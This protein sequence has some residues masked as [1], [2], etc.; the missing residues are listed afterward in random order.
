MIIFERLVVAEK[1]LFFFF[2][3]EGPNELILQNRGN[4]AEADVYTKRR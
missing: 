1:F 4:G 3:R 2:G